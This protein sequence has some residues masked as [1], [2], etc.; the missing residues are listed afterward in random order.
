LFLKHCTEQTRALVSSLIYDILSL[1]VSFQ[2][3][4][5]LLQVLSVR[6]QNLLQGN[7]RIENYHYQ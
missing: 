4:V 7:N 6:R 5:M 3:M 1:T 2:V